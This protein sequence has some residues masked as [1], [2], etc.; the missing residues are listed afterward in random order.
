MTE[1]EAF[2]LASCRLLSRARKSLYRFPIELGP[3]STFLFSGWLRVEEKAQRNMDSA[4]RQS[5]SEPFTVLES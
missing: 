1:L 2:A 3:A 4:A 5:P